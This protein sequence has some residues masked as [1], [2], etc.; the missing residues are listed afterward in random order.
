MKIHFDHS[1][2]RTTDMD[3][4]FSNVW[5]EVNH[6][7]LTYAPTMGWLPDE[8]DPP[9]WFTGRQVRL[10]LRQFN[11]KHKYPRNLHYALIEVGQISY[12]RL[13]RIWDN[14]IESRRYTDHLEYHK[15]IEYQ[16]E[17]K[18]LVL[19]YDRQKIVAFSILR[20]WPIFV[21]LQFA[22]NY[23]EPKLS[24]GR[25]TQYYEM[26]YAKTHNIKYNYLC[27]GYETNCI[28]KSNFPGFQWWDGSNWQTD[29]ERYER[30][31]ERDSQLKNIFE[32]D[33]I[34]TE[35]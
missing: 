30:L 17:H 18:R 29:K 12:S 14:Y 1:F 11:G 8:W 7:E 23:H 22:W 33:N 32:L 6:D 9:K 10:D 27:P 24:V 3:V 35:I 16:P 5:A 34:S 25:H 19:V 21:S 4:S 15:T 26:S 20:I 13:D 2:G 28:W 31:C